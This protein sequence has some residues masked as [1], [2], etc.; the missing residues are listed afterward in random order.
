MMDKFIGAIES[1]KVTAQ[2]KVYNEF[3]FGQ[4]TIQPVHSELPPYSHRISPMDMKVKERNPN[5]TTLF[6]P[7]KTVPKTGN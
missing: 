4:R 3:S 1:S 6:D 7:L 2:V 5:Q